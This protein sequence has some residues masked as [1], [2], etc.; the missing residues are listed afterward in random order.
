MEI[1]LKI[2]FTLG[3][4]IREMELKKFLDVVNAIYLEVGG[5]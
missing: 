1:E 2:M 3:A 5:D 4:L